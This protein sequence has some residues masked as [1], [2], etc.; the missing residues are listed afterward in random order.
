M[1]RI[2]IFIIIDNDVMQSTIVYIL[3]YFNTR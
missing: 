1:S 2:E 3:I